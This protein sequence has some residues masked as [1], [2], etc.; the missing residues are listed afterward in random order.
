M[1]RSED[2]F[3]DAASVILAGVRE[4]IETDILTCNKALQI[5]HRTQPLQPLPTA[6]AGTEW[7]AHPPLQAHGLPKNLSQNTQLAYTC[8]HKS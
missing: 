8:A 4:F 3:T 2:I 7:H 1:S 6:L 5:S